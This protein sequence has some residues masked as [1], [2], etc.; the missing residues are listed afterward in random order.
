[1]LVLEKSSDSSAGKE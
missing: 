1:M